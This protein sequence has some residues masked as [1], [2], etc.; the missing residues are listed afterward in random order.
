MSS[1]QREHN[2]GEKWLQVNETEFRYCQPATALFQDVFFLGSFDRVDAAFGLGTAAPTAGA[3]S[4]SGAVRLVQGM[5]PT[6]R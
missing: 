5:Q 2:L 4:S 1:D 3:A 6:D